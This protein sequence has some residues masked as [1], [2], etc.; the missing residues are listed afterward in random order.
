MGYGGVASGRWVW[1]VGEVRT[2]VWVWLMGE[3]RTRVWL[4]GVVRTRGEVDMT[5][6]DGGCG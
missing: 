5:S 1:L 2:R 4:V 3:V 6:M